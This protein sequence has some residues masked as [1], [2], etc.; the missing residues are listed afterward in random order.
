MLRNSNEYVGVDSLL[1]P[2]EV[3]NLYLVYKS[4]SCVLAALRVDDSL[5]QVNFKMMLLMN[6]I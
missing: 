2:L 6:F 3:P 1:L 5:Q 4:S